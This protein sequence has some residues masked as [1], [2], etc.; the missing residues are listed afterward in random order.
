[1][2]QP[3]IVENGRRLTLARRMQYALETAAAFVA[4]VFFRLFSV[5]RASAIGGWFGRNLMAR[6][7]VT[8]RARV[9]L[10][11]ALPGISDTEV[12]RIVRAMWDNLGRTAAEYGHLAAFRMNG[13][14]PRLVCEGYEHI[15][16]A[17]A[18][19]KGAIVVSGHFANWEMMILTSGQY[20]TPGGVVYRPPNNPWVDRWITGQRV[21]HGKLEMI[22]KG[23]QGTRRIFTLLR[24]G[25]AIH[26]LVDQKT[27]EGVPVP[28]F[29][30][31]AMT[32]PA[33]AALALK[34]GAIIVPAVARRVAGSRFRM[35]VYPPIEPPLPTGDHARDIQAF[36]EKISS[37]IEE[38]V[39]ERPEQW[40]WI[41]R[42]WTEPG[43]LV[44]KRAQALLP[45]AGPAESAGSNRS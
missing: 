38:R 45:G 2:T 5:D 44:R 21:L 41:H 4:I 32:T 40:L 26:M 27:N 15:R 25:E 39:R 37:F 8:N 34:L 24:R 35:T 30:R 11:N 28:F 42:R 36:T 10:R 43:G 3:T 9:N 20:G 17:L 14:D 22:T 12:G 6:L 33:P 31:P 29:G 18:R 13:D 7:G 23:A 16:A 19:G 1:M